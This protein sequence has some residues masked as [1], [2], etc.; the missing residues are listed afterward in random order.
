MNRSEVN[1][2]VVDCLDA[3]LWLRYVHIVNKTPILTKLASF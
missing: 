1:V 3:F 2:A